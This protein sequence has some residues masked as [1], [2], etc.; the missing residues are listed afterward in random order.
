[1]GPL[2]GVFFYSGRIRKSMFVYVQTAYF[3]CLAWWTEEVSII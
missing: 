1:M 3:V 2:E